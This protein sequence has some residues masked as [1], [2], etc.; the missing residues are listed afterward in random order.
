M[1]SRRRAPKLIDR[2]LLS[3]WPLPKLPENADKS[4]RGDVLVVGGS[5][6]VPGAVLLAGEAALRSGSGRVR[7][8]TARSAAAALAVAFPEARVLGVPETRAGELDLSVRNALTKELTQ[9]DAV[10][11][12]PGMFDAGAASALYRRAI[13]SSC[14]AQWI[15]DAAALRIL[16]KGRPL[17]QG[18][19]QG[20][21]ATP[22]AGEM[23]ELWS[24][25]IRQVHANPLEIA[26]EAARSFGITLVLKGSRSFIVAPDGTAFINTAGN[27]GLATAGSGDVLAG[28][29]SGLAA[30]G[31][32]P[33]QAA[34]WGVYLH[35]LAG[36][37]LARQRGP[38]GYLARELAGEVPALLEA[39]GRRR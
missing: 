22:H 39:S 34:V 4:A 15:V 23:A 6:S 28:I 30:R 12:G 26:F 24:C 38:L 17:E 25:S 2:A 31:A 9:S 5:R 21:I 7:I 8:A 1:K 36:V 29:I 13:G 14:R 19:L 35:A 16:S 33:L 18:S 11:V 3:R 37:R 20:V 10:L 27:P 32:E